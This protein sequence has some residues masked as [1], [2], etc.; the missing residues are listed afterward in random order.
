MFAI[1]GPQSAGSSSTETNWTWNPLDKG[2]LV[3]L[4]D[5]D[6]TATFG[7]TANR[8]VRGT[9]AITG[10]K[11]FVLQA[12]TASSTA[13]GVAN[14]SQPLG[15]DPLGSGTDSVGRLSTIIFYNSTPVVTGLPALANDDLVMFA[16]DAAT[17]RVWIGN[18][19]SGTWYN[20]GDPAAGTG[21]VASITGTLY[22][23][24]SGTDA[25]PSVAT[26]VSIALPTGFNR[27]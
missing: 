26:V 9:T 3:T 23:A 11:F 5:G 1:P 19:L 15:N 21:Y 20:S 27:L 12:S 7:G 14:S 24:A 4:S 18:Y 25:A 8:V 2:D 16:V 6:K 17:G 22:P 10:M 13:L